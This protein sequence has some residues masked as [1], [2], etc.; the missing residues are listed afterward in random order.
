MLQ[1][2]L[3]LPQTFFLLRKESNTALIITRNNK[4][5]QTCKT[6]PNKFKV[7]LLMLYFLLASVLLTLKNYLHVIIIPSLKASDK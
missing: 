2:S 1:I 6:I 4:T 3:G 5:K 7:S